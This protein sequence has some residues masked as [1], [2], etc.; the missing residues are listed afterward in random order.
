MQPTLLNKALVAGLIIAMAAGGAA[1]RW[2]FGER[3]L[4]NYAQRGSMAHDDAKNQGTIAGV[5]LV[6]IAYLGALALA[7]LVRWFMS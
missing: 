4:K 3:A 2:I 7:G 5:L 1:G 6:F